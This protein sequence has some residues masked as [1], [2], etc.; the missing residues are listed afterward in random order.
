MR[1]TMGTT[2][3]IIW[4]NDKQVF[5]D[6]LQMNATLSPKNCVICKLTNL[7]S[8]NITFTFCFVAQGLKR[9]VC[10]PT[11]DSRD[12]NPKMKCSAK[13]IIFPIFML[14][15]VQVSDSVTK[16]YKSASFMYFYSRFLW[17]FIYK[18]KHFKATAGYGSPLVKPCPSLLHMHC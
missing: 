7:L 2:W 9:A 15:E 8:K 14:P 12:T 17:I 6:K 11:S 5:E 10:H 1:N 3:F 18:A 4:E 16:N 13:A